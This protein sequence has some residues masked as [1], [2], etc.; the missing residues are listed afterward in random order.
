VWLKKIDSKLLETS[1]LTNI[2]ATSG[3]KY[4]QKYAAP[5]RRDVFRKSFN[6]LGGKPPNLGN[7]QKH[8]FCTVY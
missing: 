7:L 8:D 1:N 4:I 3:A 6:L 5:E 2:R